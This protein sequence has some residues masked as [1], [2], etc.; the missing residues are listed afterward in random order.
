MTNPIIESIL[1][2]TI[3][4]TKTKRKQRLAAEEEENDFYIEILQQLAIPA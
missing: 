4:R 2:S 3:S 1:K